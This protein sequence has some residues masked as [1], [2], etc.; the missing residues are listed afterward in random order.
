MTDNYLK[1][2]T[3]ALFCAAGC[4]TITP[5]ARLEPVGPNPTLTARNAGP[6]FL[7]VFSARERIPVDVNGEE[8]FYDNDYGRNAFL[9]YAAHTSYAIYAPDGRQVQQVRNNAGN[10]NNPDP[11]TV[12]LSPGVYEVVAAAEDYGDVTY[13]VRIPVVIEPGLT[14]RV[15]LDGQWSPA[16]CG[17]QQD[18]L[19]CLPNGHWAGWRSPRPVESPALSQANI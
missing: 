17:K 4:T 1:F 6:G 5:T 7:Q 10:M 15:H 2:V 14:T 19:V 18:K 3:V 8:F 12:S 9:R 16:V 11:S 13:P